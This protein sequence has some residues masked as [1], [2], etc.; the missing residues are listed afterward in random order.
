MRGTTDR[1]RS[2]DVWVSMLWRLLVRAADRS[3]SNFCRSLSGMGCRISALTIHCSQGTSS[4]L[5]NPS[6]DFFWRFSEK[7][8]TISPRF[9]APPSIPFQNRSTFWSTRNLISWSSTPG[10]E[11]S[12]ISL[13]SGLTTPN[14]RWNRIECN[15]AFK[16]SLAVRL[17]S[18]W[19]VYCNDWKI[20]VRHRGSQ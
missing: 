2:D 16:T 5:I 10:M 14:S 3:E 19:Q 9:F 18:T 7:V 17:S 1:P 15:T 20:T 12:K 4:S 8:T 11:I 13:V 6:Q